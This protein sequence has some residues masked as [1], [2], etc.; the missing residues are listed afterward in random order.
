[1]LQREPS[2][3]AQART[4]N[5]ETPRPRPGSHRTV[6]NPLLCPCALRPGAR[7]QTS[8]AHGS[9]SVSSPCL[10]M[11]VCLLLQDLITKLF[12]G[13]GACQYLFWCIQCLFCSDTSIQCLFQWWEQYKNTINNGPVVYWRRRSNKH[14]PHY[15]RSAWHQ[16]ERGRWGQGGRN[17]GPSPQPR[18]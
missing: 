2:R 16:T 1:M 4:A 14:S 11:C 17:V 8:V 12:A 5:G 13:G 9:P 3:S 10:Q 18:W 6:R 7:S 15:F